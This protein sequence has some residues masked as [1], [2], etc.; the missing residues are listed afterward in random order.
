VDLARLRLDDGM[1]RAT[2]ALRE[3]TAQIANSTGG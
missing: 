2:Q 1:R 3:L